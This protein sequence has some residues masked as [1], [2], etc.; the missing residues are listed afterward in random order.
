MISQI[1]G[2][3]ERASGFRQVLECGVKRRFSERA[4]WDRFATCLGGGERTR[5][6]G[7]G[8]VPKF[9]VALLVSSASGDRL[10]TCPTLGTVPLSGIRPSRY[11]VGHPSFGS[12]AT[13]GAFTTSGSINA[14]ASLIT[15]SIMM[16]TG[17]LG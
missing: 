17:N 11:F 14:S 16:Q 1:A 10:Q 15:I 2:D 12:A 13:C 7:A 4:R 9:L 8:C 5:L 6:S 3:F